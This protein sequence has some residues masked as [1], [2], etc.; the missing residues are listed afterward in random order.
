MELLIGDTLE[1]R[2]SLEG[3]DTN[4][5]MW[6][7]N[8]LDCV[9]TREV[10]EVSADAVRSL[11]LTEADRFQHAMFPAVL[12]AMIRGVKIDLNAREAM[13]KELDFEKAKR[14]AWLHEVVGFPLNVGSSKQMKAYFYDDMG[15]PVVKKRRANGTVTPSLDDAAMEILKRKEPLV[16]PIFRNIAETRSIG[17]FRSTFIGARLGE[18]QRM[19]CS[20]NMCGTETFRFSSSQDAFGSG[21]NL[22]NIPKGGE[23]DDSDLVLPNIRKIF[24]PDSDHTFFDIDLSKAD[25]RV[26]VWESDCHEMKAMLAEGRDPY[27]ESAR[28]YY[29]DPTISKYNPDGTENIKYDNFK[30]FSHGTHY[31]GTPS[32]LSQRIGLTVNEATKTQAWYFGKYP[33]IKQWQEKFIAEIKRTHRVRNKFGFVR[34]YLGRIDDSTFREAIAWLPQSTVG[35]LIN[36]IWLRIWEATRRDQALAEV[37][38]QV[39]DSLCGQFPSARREEAL[40]CIRR[41]GEVQIPYDDPL[42]IPIGIKL[43][44]VSWGHCA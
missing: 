41:A 43:S 36:K 11:N 38:L 22:Q 37:L 28:E 20:Y 39:H 32:G 44:D 7:Y 19:R 34:N 17:V 27:I 13:R 3:L 29:R 4:L 18:D 40:A 10:G 2:T 9:Y 15:L 26:V 6:A 35:I 25:L 14:I 1:P 16:R 31:L 21:T 42:I 23:D 24:I 33:E 8:S 5:S 30:R 12:H